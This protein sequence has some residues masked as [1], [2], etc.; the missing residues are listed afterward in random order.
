MPDDTP[1]YEDWHVFTPGIDRSGDPP[2]GIY[3]FTRQRTNARK[4]HGGTN[5]F[6][7]TG[8]HVHGDADDFLGLSLRSKYS[9]SGDP[10]AN[11]CGTV[12][13]SICRIVLEGYSRSPRLP[14]ALTAG[15]AVGGLSW[16]PVSVTTIALGATSGDYPPAATTS[17]I[18]ILLGGAG[19]YAPP[20]V[21]TEIC[22]ALV[23][24]IGLDFGIGLSTCGIAIEA[25]SSIP[26][27]PADGGI[28][29]GYSVSGSDGGIVLGAFT[30]FSAG[31]MLLGS[32]SIVSGPLSAGLDLGFTAGGERGGLEFGFSAGSERGGLQFGFSAGSE[33]GGLDL[34][35]SAGVERGGLDLGFSASMAH[36]INLGMDLGF[37]AGVERGGLDLGFSAGVERGGMDLGFS[38]GVEPGGLDLGFSAGVERGGLDL[39]FSAADSGLILG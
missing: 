34:G 13:A 8:D 23:G 19:V 28:V 31:G 7:T 29:L 30:T 17:F 37:S 20:A 12:V 33:R 27:A 6:G 3:E 15:I 36:L 24:A 14:E 32:G 39:G 4:H 18:G 22:A 38:A 35:F 21:P 5:I 26:A 11:P 2:E 10:P 9:P 25:S 16:D 1:I